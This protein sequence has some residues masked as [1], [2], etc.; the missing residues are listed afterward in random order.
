MTT[1]ETLGIVSLVLSFVV[2]IVGGIVGAYVG[3]KVGIAKLET[4]REVF[5]MALHEAQGDIRVLNEDSLV[6]DTEISTVMTH[7]NIARARR[8]RFRD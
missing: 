8:Q 1:Q 6:H 5:A 4:W 3:M 2:G 7:L